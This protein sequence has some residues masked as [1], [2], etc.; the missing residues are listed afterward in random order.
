MRE[1][2]THPWFPDMHVS[3]HACPNA[4]VEVSDL[5]FDAMSVYSRGGVTDYSS[6][7]NTRQLWLRYWLLTLVRS[8]CVQILASNILTSQK[9][10]SE[11]LQT[12]NE[13][14]HGGVTGPDTLTS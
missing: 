13:C 12:S 1:L 7:A 14:A 11:L 2:K 9:Q 5:S 6:N 3:M 10:I 8:K 4:H